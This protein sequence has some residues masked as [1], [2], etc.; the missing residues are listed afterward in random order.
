MGRA[1]M[2]RVFAF[3]GAVTYLT[4]GSAFADSAVSYGNNQDGLGLA[5]GLGLAR[6]ETD[7]AQ[8][9]GAGSRTRGVNGFR[10][11]IERMDYSAAI[12]GV[13]GTPAGGV[14]STSLMLNGLYEFS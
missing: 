5:P 3:A 9:A 14:R 8:T 2:R 10:T 7:A 11:E 4:I 13:S 12:P 1:A 6:S